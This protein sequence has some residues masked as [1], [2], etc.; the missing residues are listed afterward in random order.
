MCVGGGGGGGVKIYTY[1]CNY[2]TNIHTFRLRTSRVNMCDRMR[3]IHHCRS[4]DRKVVAS[5]PRRRRHKALGCWL[6]DTH[7][8]QATYRTYNVDEHQRAV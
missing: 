3:A 6:R 1:V 4:T 8:E 2:I 7:V 5:R